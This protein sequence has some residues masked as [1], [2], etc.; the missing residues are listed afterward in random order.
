MGYPVTLVDVDP[1]QSATRWNTRA[2]DAADPLPFPVISHP[3]PDQVLHDDSDR[4]AEERSSMLL[5][6]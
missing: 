1:R 5:A 3:L 4:V 6:R 2:Q